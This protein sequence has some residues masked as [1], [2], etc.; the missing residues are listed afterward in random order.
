MFVYAG[1]LINIHDTIDC[2]VLLYRWPSG[3]SSFANSSPNVPD[4]YR[5]EVQRI[6]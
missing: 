2:V 1:V 3:R 4:S 5:E 6:A